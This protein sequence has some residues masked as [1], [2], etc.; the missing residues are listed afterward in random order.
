MNR[1]NGRER[2]MMLSR[3]Q[4]IGHMF[5]FVTTHSAHAQLSYVQVDADDEC[6][7]ACRNRAATMY[8]CTVSDVHTPHDAFLYAMT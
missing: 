5:P 6:Y 4:V 7:A 2:K 3:A 8:M 1:A